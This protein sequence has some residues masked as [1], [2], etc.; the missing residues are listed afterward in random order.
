M[1]II[2]EGPP[3]HITFHQFTQLP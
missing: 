2:N 1:D 3:L